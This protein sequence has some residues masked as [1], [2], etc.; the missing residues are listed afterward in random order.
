M[1]S[2]PLGNIMYLMTLTLCANAHL[3]V[4]GP[5]VWSGQ[6]VR[7]GGGPALGA[8]RAVFLALAALQ[9]DAP[10]TLD[11]RRPLAPLAA[12]AAPAGG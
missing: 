3:K 11:G 1:S 8:R 12:A 9:L 6:W 5:G 7:A 10:L 2:D 4:G